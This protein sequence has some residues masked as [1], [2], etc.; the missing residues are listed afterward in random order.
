MLQNAS[1]A[2]SRRHSRSNCHVTPEP[3]AVLHEASNEGTGYMRLTIFA[4][5]TAID[6]ARVVL[7]LV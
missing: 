5:A 1:P 3:L 2:G 6:D 4:F 7:E